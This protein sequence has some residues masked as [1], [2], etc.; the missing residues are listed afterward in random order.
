M[1][2]RTTNYLTNARLIPEILKSKEQGRMNNELAKMLMLLVQRYAKH[3]WYCNY[4]YNDEMQSEAL[5]HL[6][7]VWDRFD[8]AKSSNAFGFYTQCLKHMFSTVK[9]REK[10]QR[11]IRDALIVEQGALPSFTYQEEHKSFDEEDLS[12]IR[13]EMEALNNLRKNPEPEEVVET[14]VQ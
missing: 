4:T 8:P 13:D 12:C 14:N 5:L 7:K 11:N 9:N 10:E 6:C 2:K 1:A 3:P